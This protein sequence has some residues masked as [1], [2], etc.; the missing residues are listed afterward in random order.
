MISEALWIQAGIFT[1]VQ[2]SCSIPVGDFKPT[3]AIVWLSCLF[4]GFPIGTAVLLVFLQGFPIFIFLAGISQRWFPAGDFKPSTGQQ[5]LSTQHRTK[6]DTHNLLSGF[7]FS[8]F[9][10]MSHLSCTHF[11]SGHASVRSLC[12]SICKQLPMWFQTHLGNCLAILFFLRISCWDIHVGDFPLAQLSVLLVFFSRISHL[13][14]SC[15]SFIEMFSSGWVQTHLQ[16]KPTIA[17]CD[18]S[19]QHRKKNNGIPSLKQLA[20]RMYIVQ[21]VSK[22]SWLICR[23]L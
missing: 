15:R 8:L 14:L 13:H 17:Q 4:L 7:I 22:L 6:H 20:S 2:V 18:L 9:W 5:D 11:S 23:N 19:T 12:R 16:V 1:D 21:M 3:L 10:K